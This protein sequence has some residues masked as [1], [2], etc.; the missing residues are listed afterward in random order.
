MIAS[1]FTP[2]PPD[3]LAFYHPQMALAIANGV[4]LRP[5]LRTLS[6]KFSSNVLNQPQPA[7][8][9]QQIGSYSIFTGSTVTLD[10]TS[11][12]PGN[13]LKTTSDANQAKVTG[14]TV[15]LQLLG[16]G[17]AGD[18]SPIP[19]AT[20]LQAAKDILNAQAGVWAMNNPDNPK[21]L[22]TLTAAPPEVPLT[23]W[24][25]FCFGVLGPGGEEFMCMSPQAARAELRKMGVICC[26]P[27]AASGTP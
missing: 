25:I 2:P 9:D 15:T 12:F 16:S 5:N 8:F 11:A 20:P 19:T 26:A 27:G 6:T 22:F 3:V 24:W 17:G 14:I 21:A 1:L 23:V 4:R 10:P 13:V 18:Y 7:S